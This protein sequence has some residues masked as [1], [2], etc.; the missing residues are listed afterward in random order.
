VV[1][2]TVEYGSQKPKLMT[3][4]PFGIGKASLVRKLAYECAKGRSAG[5]M[6]R[7]QSQNSHSILH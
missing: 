2:L 6:F 5:V 4:V 3:G 1:N 7:L